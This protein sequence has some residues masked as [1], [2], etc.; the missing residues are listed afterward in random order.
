MNQSEK[1]VNEINQYIDHADETDF[2]KYSQLAASYAER[3]SLLNQQINRASEQLHASNPCEALRQIEIF[4]LIEEYSCLNFDRNEEWRG[5]CRDL[6]LPVPETLLD[7]KAQELVSLVEL[8]LPLKPLLA[9]HHILAMEGSLKDRLNVLYQIAAEDQLESAWETMIAEY[10]KAEI[11]Q[12]LEA[13]PPGKKISLS[14]EE[15]QDYLKTLTNPARHTPAPRDLL[16]RLNGHLQEIGLNQNLEQLNQTALQ[17][18]EA[19]Q[20]GDTA[21]VEKYLTSCSSL[22]KRIPQNQIPSETRKMMSDSL[23]WM[24]QIQENKKRNALFQNKLSLFESLIANEESTTEELTAAASATAMAAQNCEEEIPE[25]LMRAYRHRIQSIE[26]QKQR[27]FII[28]MVILGISLVLIGGGIF[29]GT[30]MMLF[31]RGVEKEVATFAGYIEKYDGC[32]TPDPNALIEGRKFYERLATE[33]GK[34]C[35]SAPIQSLKKQLEQLEQS[36]KERTEFF[37]TQSKNVEE[38]LSRNELLGDMIDQLRAKAY[39]EEEKLIVT[40]FENRRQKILTSEQKVRDE[41]YQSH[42]V[43]LSNIAKE[44]DSGKKRTEEET[45]SLYEDAKRELAEMEQLREKEKISDPLIATSE[46]LQTRIQNLIEFMEE[47]KRIAECLQKLTESVGN[48][49]QFTKEMKGIKDQYPDSPEAKEFSQTLSILPKIE[50]ISQWN[51]LIENY[52][53]NTFQWE[54][55]PIQKEL[56]QDLANLQNKI[57]F[58]NDCQNIVESS[59]IYLKILQSSGGRAKILEELRSFL[60]QYQKEYWVWSNTDGDTVQYYYFIE[61]NS[62]L[63]ESRNA[64]LHY[65]TNSLGTQ[66]AILRRALPDEPDSVKKS[67]HSSYAKMALD[68]LNQVEILTDRDRWLTTIEMILTPL[69]SEEEPDPFFDPVLRVLLQREII[70]ILCKDPLFQ[71]S[72]EENY[73]KHLDQAKEIDKDL[74][75]YDPES[76]ALPTLRSTAKSIQNQLAGPFADH[77]IHSVITSIR[78]KLVPQTTEINP[79]EWIGWLSKVD[80]E[81]NVEMASESTSNGTLYIASDQKEEIQM[82]QIGQLNQGNQNLKIDSQ[83]QGISIGTP[84]F[85][86]TEQK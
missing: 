77:Q 17:L 82:I 84:V 19:Y 25:H 28:R 42:L 36:E 49:S 6:D 73:L 67:P 69:F 74:N 47:Q 52:G 79:Y 26:L 43:K 81:W 34:V 80:K 7:D 22:I 3:C 30:K 46:R 23:K 14:P 70:T 11:A 5:I 39:T 4:H 58:L 13:V 33:N 51:H 76:T 60:S 41:K 72:F 85:I 38:A 61:Q 31:N 53:G 86:H 44:L 24:E 45:L 32:P 66:K 9:Q 56:V 12:I 21:A 54:S 29:F 16:N 71:D 35:A 20:Q 65:V 78:E 83:P 55:G 8:M 10:E 15:T 37:S 63:E 75:W 40:G 59:Y 64:H 18:H 27:R 62:P 57:P 48:F 50:I 2:A 68:A 1:I